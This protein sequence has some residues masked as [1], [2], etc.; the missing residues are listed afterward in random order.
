MLVHVVNPMVPQLGLR[1][2]SHCQGMTVL[3]AV[4]AAG[5]KLPARTVLVRG[6]EMI[7]RS[8]W[9]V[10][11]IG[12]GELALLVTLPQGGRGG[13]SQVIAFVATFALA[14][15]APEIGGAL[16]GSLGVDA[17]AAVGIG[18]LTW[19]NLATAGIF[20][21][22]S[23]LISALLPKPKALT[24]SQNTSQNP[25]YSLSA[26]SNIARLL[27][28]I[29]ERFGRMK[30]LPDLSA[31]ASFDF[32]NSQQELN[33]EFC[34]GMGEFDIEE[35]GISN[36]PIWKKTEAH[37]NGDYTGTYPEIELQIL[38][39]GAANTVFSNNQ[40]T[41]ADV[42]NIQ[43]PGANE[44]ASWI[45]PFILNPAAT[46]AQRIE[47][48]FSAPGGLFA[49]A[50]SGQLGPVTVSF[51][52]QV[53]QIDDV[54][55]PEG[56]WIT[57]I[58]KTVN[59][60]TRDAI[61]TTYGATLAPARYQVRFR[62]TNNK[63]SDLN[64]SD[65]IGILAMRGILPNTPAQADTTRIALK[66]RSTKNL[67]GDSAQRFYI[68]ATRKLPIPTQHEDGTI[69]W[70]A[71]Q[72]TRSPAWAAAYLCKAQNG[73][74]K[75]DRQVNIAKLIA[76]DAI[77]TARGD[78]FD[79]VFDDGGSAW[80]GLQTLL[81]VGRA[82]PRRIGRYIDFNRDELKLLPKAGFSPANMLAGSFNIDYLFFDANSTDGI[83]I[84]YVDERNWEPASVY[85]ALPDST[86][87]PN[88]A[89]HIQMTGVVKREQAWREGMFI[90]ACNRWR[91]IFPNFRTE[92]EGR[93]C[94][95]GDKV[96]VSHW[97][98]RW[99]YSGSVVD[100]AGTLVTLSEPWDFQAMLNADQPVLSL[101]TPDGFEW[102]PVPVEVI[103][104][105]DVT[106]QATVRL[107]GT[108]VVAKGKYAGQQPQEW[109]VWEGQGREAFE[110][111]RAT[112]GTATQKRR[113][114]LMV[115][116]KPETGNTVTMAT[117][118]DDPRVHY[119]D[120]TVPPADPDDPVGVIP[121]E[122]NPPAPAGADDLAVTGIIIS[123]VAQ[124]GGYRT[125]NLLAITVEGAKDAV[126]F[127]AQWKWNDATDFSPVVYG[128][129]RTFQIPAITGS[130]VL[131]V[132]A[133]GKS[134][135]GDWF[136]K[137]ASASALPP[138]PNAPDVPSLVVTEISHWANGESD[139]SWSWGGDGDAVSYIVK[140]QY[141]ANGGGDWNDFQVITTTNTDQTFP[142]DGVAA[143][144][145][146]DVTD[147]RA[148]V[149]PVYP[150]GTGP[151]FIA[152]T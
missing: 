118:I 125:G 26:Q 17:G 14:I 29:P 117:V 24:N 40:V 102:G 51:Q 139:G 95:R 9:D 37:P 76:L 27:Q 59:Q 148:V 15:F 54:A 73:L 30:F 101:M 111:P 62:R 134:G 133:E 151:D 64:T 58:D 12:T 132:R 4:E 127:D 25:S 142:K 131:Q 41:S 5:W 69:T 145:G 2:F 122:P 120:G 93:V 149:K 79:G 7:R 91:R 57:V 129:Q 86:T 123:E 140:L 45:G 3:E 52:V 84:D 97:L 88:D 77:W 22:G 11:P 94:F 82:E 8:E 71:P 85:C 65:A 110:R 49:I 114:A 112:W 135:F 72:A 144:P 83:W 35:I 67:N 44:D 136:T 100:L 10:T 60:A 119:A 39:P 36:N 56:E 70:S 152:P 104:A 116:M 146:I 89:P 106:A 21:A 109:P 23:T 34:L 141:Q 128:R 66:A 1:R 103:D 42:A 18:S 90:A 87:D 16:L 74:R 43:L 130:L 63:S 32:V 126:N 46:E 147:I 99:S 78:T 107:L 121:A 47:V 20:L 50:T 53:Q 19:G 92:M 31:Q 48:D 81:R 38:P 80:T 115:A 113:D 137:T 124:L 96:V 55:T 61:R 75:T 138:D 68:I 105:G 28:P 33:E 143:G 108:A 98:A 13:V 6:G 150:S